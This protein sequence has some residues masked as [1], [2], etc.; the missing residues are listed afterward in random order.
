MVVCFAFLHLV[1][2]LSI[3][4]GR[5]YALGLGF[6]C[7]DVDR[8]ILFQLEKREN[9]PPESHFGYFFVNLKMF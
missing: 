3:M 8:F 5:R 6:A 7:R 9:L 2:G 1:V 4:A